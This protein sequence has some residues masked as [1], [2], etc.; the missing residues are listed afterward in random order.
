M[1]VPPHT[2]PSCACSPVI[3][4]SFPN[5]RLLSLVMSCL[6]HRQE[7]HRQDRDDRLSVVHSPGRRGAEGGGGDGGGREEGR[8]G[9]GRGG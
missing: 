7:Y 8:R 9:E 4:F 5:T 6:I 3:D 2:D 1:D